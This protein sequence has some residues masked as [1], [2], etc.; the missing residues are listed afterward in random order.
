MTGLKQTNLPTPLKAQLAAGALAGQGSYGAIT[1]LAEQFGVSRP[2]VYSAGETA[3]VVL[4]RYF[5]ETEKEE[6]FVLVDER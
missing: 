3:D 1:D 2:T 5:E 6:R 4:T